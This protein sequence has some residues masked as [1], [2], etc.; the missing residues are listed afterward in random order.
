[1][2]NEEL[3]LRPAADLK[4]ETPEKLEAYE[5]KLHLR[6]LRNT[7]VEINASHD[8][9]KTYC[10]VDFIPDSVCEELKKN[11]YKVIREAS[12]FNIDWG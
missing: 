10:Y 4:K 1:M 5:N 8:S 11:G 3:V 9:G 7:V 2:E 12:Y 6:A